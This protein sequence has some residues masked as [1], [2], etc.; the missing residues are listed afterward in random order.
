MLKKTKLQNRPLLT[1]ATHFSKPST[2]RHGFGT[3]NDKQFLQKRIAKTPIP[4]KTTFCFRR[5]VELNIWGKKDF[6]GTRNIGR[7][8]SVTI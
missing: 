3:D 4:K 6:L 2:I 7:G 8:P 5:L 1:Q